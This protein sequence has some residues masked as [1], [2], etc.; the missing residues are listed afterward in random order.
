MNDP[1]V[2]EQAR[3]LAARLL[4]EGA[5]SQERIARAFRLAFGR[6]PSAQEYEQAMSY[7]AE[8]RDRLR[9]QGVAETQLASRT[10]ESFAR[11]IFMSSE[12]VYVN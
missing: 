11:V 12:F 2:H 5:G 6:S 9:L 10:W 1:F 3:K 7:L 4:A 8:V